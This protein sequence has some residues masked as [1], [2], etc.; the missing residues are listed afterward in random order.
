MSRSIGFLLLL[1]ACAPGSDKSADEFHVSV[2]VQDKRGKAVGSAG[3]RL[4]E[5]V[6]Q[7]GSDGAWEVAV[8]GKVGEK[9]LASVECPSGFSQDSENLE[10][11]MRRQRALESGHELPLKVRF[12]C[13]R[14]QRTV[15]LV[16]RTRIA[17]IPILIDGVR[18]G[19]TDTHG[20]AHIPVS[21][22]GTQ[23]FVVTLDTSKRPELRPQ[24]PSLRFSIEDESA[25]STFDQVFSRAA[26]SRPRRP[27]RKTAPANTRPKKIG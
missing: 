6:G 2:L 15:A 3:V 19:T 23:K 13:R 24:N 18:L 12:L 14:H 26:K 25:I 4:G 9:L 27:R 7:T 8:T 22:E 5:K 21:R 20:V 10:V 11:K 1:A 16:V 17:N